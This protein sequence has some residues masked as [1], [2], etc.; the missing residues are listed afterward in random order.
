LAAI[1]NGDR[2]ALEQVYLTHKDDLLT[3]AMYLL[4]ERN[5]AEDA[6]HDVF[7]ALPPRASKVALRGSLKGYLMASCVNR[8]RDMLRTQ[9]RQPIERALV[10]ERVSGSIQ[11]PEAVE[12]EE[13]RQQLVS[14]VACLPI[15]QREVLTLHIHGQ[16]TFPDVAEQLDIP[17]NTAQ[18]RYRYALVALRRLLQ[19]EDG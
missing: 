8:A 16:L 10:G 13:R 3:A 15:E 2:H 4:R 7:V 9:A 5:L 19:V 6:L 14:A 12:L 11:P 1:G 17:L 18:S